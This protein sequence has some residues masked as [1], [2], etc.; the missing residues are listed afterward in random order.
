VERP[1]SLFTSRFNFAEHPAALSVGGPSEAM[2]TRILPLCRSARAQALAPQRDQEKAHRKH[3]MHCRLKHG[4]KS[5]LINDLDYRIF[6]FWW[7]A[8]NHTHRFVE[9][10]KNVRLSIREWKRQREIYRHPRK[11]KRFDVGFASFYLNRT[12]RSGILINGGPIGGIKQD[13]AWKLNARFYRA[14]LADRI[15]RIAA[16]RERIMIS[17]LDALA[18]IRKIIKSYADEELFIYLDPPYYEKGS[19]LYLSHY[20]HNDHVAVGTAL[21]ECG[22]HRWVVTYDDV[23]AIRSIYR[24]CHV[25]PFALR[26]TAQRRRSGAELFIAPRGLVVPRKLLQSLV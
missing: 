16:Y 10:I 20:D 14:T 6:A 9:Q 5:V 17:N 13:G 24:G 3:F 1:H 8:L 22:D 2:I 7:A 18:F 12:N 4:L 26:Y 15:E 19:E 25:L 11:H 21:R 23:P